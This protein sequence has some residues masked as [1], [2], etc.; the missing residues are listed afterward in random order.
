MP[1]PSPACGRWRWPRRRSCGPSCSASRSIWPSAASALT[2]TAGCRPMPSAC[3]GDQRRWVQG[4]LLEQGLA[5]AYVKRVTAPAPGG[6]RGR[7][8]GARGAARP[9]GGCRLPGEAG[10][11]PSRAL[12]LSGTFQVVEGRIARV[13]QGRGIDLSQFRCRLAARFS[14]S[15][16]RGDRGLL[17]PNADDPKALEGKLVRVRGWIEQRHGPTSICRLPA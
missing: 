5:R 17:G 11:K 16:R 7:T 2:A 4:H 6:S 15:L 12:A 9:V 8:R 10:R 1:A 14:V 13:A 3:E